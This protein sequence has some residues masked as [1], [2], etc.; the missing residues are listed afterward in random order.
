M[1]LYDFR[2]TDDACEGV[3][4]AF[5]SY[6]NRD[7]APPCACGKPTART[8]MPP[9]VMRDIAEYTSPMDGTRITSRSQH[10]DH[11]KRHRVI[12]VGNEQVKP[13]ARPPARTIIREELRNQV[14]RMKFEGKLVDR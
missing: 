2:C 7:E 10:R 1:P 13:V 8:F 11:M 14:Q 5:R 12:E 3:Q 4:E 6:E 9:R